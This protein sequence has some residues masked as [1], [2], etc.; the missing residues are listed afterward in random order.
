MR[1]NVGTVRDV[2][3]A[4]SVI[5]TWRA[6]G[7]A[8]AL[9][10][11]AAAQAAAPEVPGAD[12]I[13]TRT[14]PNGMKVVVWPDRDIPNVAMY[15]WY[16]V[17]SR[18]ERPGITGISHFFEHMMF[19]GTKTRAP[20][21]FDRVMEG[22]GGSNNAYT[23]SDVTVYQNWFPSSVTGL[24]F[25]LESDRMR[26]LD[27][28]AEKVESERGVVYSERRSSIDNDNFGTLIEQMQATAF[29][30]HPYQIPTIGWPSDIEGWRVSD[31]QD[32]YRQYYAPNNAVMFI[33]GDIEPEAA[34]KLA[35]S[36]LPAFRRNPRHPP[37]RRK[38]RR[39]SAS[40]GSGSNATP[41][42]R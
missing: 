10:C 38:S 9:V 5:T 27:F 6:A 31:L 13:V 1:N 8:L 30:A 29:V 34:F 17:G 36:T 7:L 18:N 23:S 41:R 33:V 28:N 39:N 26:N 15:T 21:E 3:G 20:G 19:N 14:L 22:S 11:G 42:R 25:D 24:I 2:R 12:Q 37:S 35:D 16:R 4:S 40:G 32:Y